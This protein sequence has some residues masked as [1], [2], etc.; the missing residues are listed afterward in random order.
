MKPA[1]FAC[2]LA[3]A[4]SP[5]AAQDAGWSFAAS[6]YLWLPALSTSI[7]TDEGTIDTDLSASDAIADLEFAFMGAFEARNGRWGLIGDLI[8]SDIQLSSPSRRGQL[9]DKTT[10]ETELGVFSGYVMYRVRETTDV[11]FDIGGGF[12]GYSADVELRLKGNLAED[13]DFG[14]GET[15]VDPLVAAR[16]IVPFSDKWFGTAFA[17]FGGTGSDEMTYQ[18]LASVGYRFNARWSAQAAYRYLSIEKS[19]G[20]REVEI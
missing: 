6:A 1:A 16:V 9:F 8:Y 15:W 3:A 17:D 7:D 11:A 10:L 14:G 20:G 4:A 13:R 2:A 19:F 12:R 18:A 5:A